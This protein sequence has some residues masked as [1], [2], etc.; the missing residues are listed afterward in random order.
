MGRLNSSFIIELFIFICMHDSWRNSTSEDVLD[1]AIVMS[2]FNAL[3]IISIENPNINTKVTL[4]LIWINDKEILNEQ[5]R[6]TCNI[7]N[8]AL[9]EDKQNTDIFRYI[10]WTYMIYITQLLIHQISSVFNMCYWC[11]FGMWYNAFLTINHIA[12]QNNVEII[13]RIEQTQT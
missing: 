9:N 5:S 2:N 1:Y 13:L 7:R 6:G 4:L 3:G 11:R 12:K 8:T 10:T